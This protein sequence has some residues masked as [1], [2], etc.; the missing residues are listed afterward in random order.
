[1]KIKF[2]LKRVLN[3]YE[4]SNK[5]DI[6]SIG[7][8]FYELLFGKRIFLIFLNKNTAPFTAS[9]MIDLIKNIQS[10]TLDIPRRINKVSPM[11]EDVLRKMLVVDPKKRVDWEDLFN[12]PINHY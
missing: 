3:G 5:A 6:W 7:T 12:H 4:Y 11:I 2:D 1:M 8:V 9:N 10:K